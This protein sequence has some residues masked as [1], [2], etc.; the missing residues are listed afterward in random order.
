MEAIR[1][2]H[3]LKIPTFG[4]CYGEQLIARTLAGERFVGAAQAG[5]DEHG[6]VELETVAGAG[7]FQ[8][9]PQRFYSFAF[10]RDEVKS[11]PD[12]FRLTASSALCPVQA[13]ELKDAP[14]WG[15]QFHPERGLEAG[16]RGLDRRSGAD[17]SL[18]VLNRE[19]GAQV[20]DPQVARAIFRNFL[21]LVWGGDAG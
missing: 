8:G 11:L 19:K 17:P 7:I 10:H 18:P 2:L 20:F 21:R 9:L 16:N 14:F 5:K 4:I 3:A 1:R 15:V 6:W 13:F 12:G